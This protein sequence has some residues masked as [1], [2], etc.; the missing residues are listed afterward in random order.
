MVL[1]RIEN[2]EYII[3]NT[4]IPHSSSQIRISLDRRYYATYEMMKDCYSCF[5]DFVYYGSNNEFQTLANE[6]INN[7]DEQRWHLLPQAYEIT[8]TL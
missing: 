4:L 3:Q 5:N 6:R 1:D 8:L 2:D 7:M